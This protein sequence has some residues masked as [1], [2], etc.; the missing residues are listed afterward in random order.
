MND[1]KKDPGSR[2]KQKDVT[3]RKP[4]KKREHFGEDV[5]GDGKLSV[6]RF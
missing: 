3:P 6:S 4:R 1:G 2:R 5:A